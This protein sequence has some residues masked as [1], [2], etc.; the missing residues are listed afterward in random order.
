MTSPPAKSPA[1]ADRSAAGPTE[2]S[3]RAQSL[4][5]LRAL[6]YGQ[7]PS[8]RRPSLRGATR[9]V[10]DAV[11]AAP[12]L[13]Q[14]IKLQIDSQHRLQAV[15]ALLPPTLRA[16][17]QAGPVEDTTWCLLVPNSAAAAKLRQLLPA[18]CAHLRSQGWQVQTIRLKI[19]ARQP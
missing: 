16:H 10:M 7:A 6:G 3:Q 2:T 13:K 8:A 14:L 17:V 19:L 15:R 5:D 12:S 9:T 1:P 11:S 18:L 4:R